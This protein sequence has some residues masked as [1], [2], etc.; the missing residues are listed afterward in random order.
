MARF[1]LLK[2]HCL[3]T[4]LGPAQFDAG[5]EI[6]SADFVNFTCTVDMSPCDEEAEKMIVD[7][8]NRLMTYST[9]LEYGESPGVGPIQNLPDVPTP[10]RK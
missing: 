6:S 10:H 4:R 3:N 8:V 5:V 2:P 9:C 1:R 7:E